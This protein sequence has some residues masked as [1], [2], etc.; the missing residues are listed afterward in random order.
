M[1]Q[2]TG[3]VYG[4]VSAMLALT[5]GVMTVDIPRHAT[6]GEM[7]PDTLTLGISESFFRDVPDDHVAL[8]LQ[9]FKALLESRTKLSGQP[10]LVAPEQLGPRLADDRLSFGVFQGF[11]FAW[12]KRA[13]ADLQPLVIA[14]PK[15]KNLRAYLVVS[16]G[17]SATTLADLKGKTLAMGCRT[18]GFCH[19]FLEREC[20]ARGAPPADFF[21][22]VCKPRNTEEALNFVVNGRADA[23]VVDGVCLDNYQEQRPTRFARLKKIVRSEVF[24][25]GVL[26]YRNGRLGKDLLR[27]FQ[28]GLVNASESPEGKELLRLCQITGFETVP[29]DFDE[30][31]THIAKVYPPPKK[32]DSK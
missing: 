9:P 23:A 20:L 6:A 32:A 31:L 28:E 5:A 10:T 25:P 27:R 13:H 7:R 3:C 18:R 15:D 26:A 30:M 11:E 16:A 4:F 29:P 8:V 22:T 2:G 14:A 1:L 24:P 17:S 21:A 19:L 12:A